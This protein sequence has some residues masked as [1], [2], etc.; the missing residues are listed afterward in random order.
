MKRF[1]KDK[2]H[3]EVSLIC[4]DTG[5]TSRA[6]QFFKAPEDFTRIPMPDTEAGVLATI[7][8]DSFRG[9]GALALRIVDIID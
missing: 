6:F 1:G 8:R 2:N 9:P 5:A 3:T 4:R 7:E